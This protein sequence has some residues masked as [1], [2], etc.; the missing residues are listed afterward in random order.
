MSLL[1]LETN[2]AFLSL[3]KPGCRNQFGCPFE[4]ILITPISIGC[5]GP[6]VQSILRILKDKPD[7]KMWILLLNQ[8]VLLSVLG[9]KETFGLDDNPIVQNE[10]WSILMVARWNLVDKK[11]FLIDLFVFIC[12]YLCSNLVFETRAMTIR[13]FVTPGT[14]VQVG[15]SQKSP[16]SLS[17][18]G[19]N[20]SSSCL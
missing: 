1:F 10:I 14:T 20:I 6:F 18:K 2:K 16:P 4:S 8:K 12:F 5:L 13:R 7:V 15:P 19:M 9:L 11:C 3:F 17:S